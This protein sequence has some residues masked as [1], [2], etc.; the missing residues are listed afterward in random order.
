[1][2]ALTGQCAQVRFKPPKP[3]SAFTNQEGR[4]LLMASNH[5]RE[6]LGAFPKA[7]VNEAELL[8]QNVQALTGLR[9]VGDLLQHLGT[10]LALRCLRMEPRLQ[11]KEYAKRELI[12]PLLYVA[13]TLAG[14][15]FHIA[16]LPSATGRG[17]S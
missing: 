14:T 8:D 11:T 15:A 1:M 5:H 16:R 2:L 6:E 12:S 9:T 17:S 3:L 10:E 13:A 7:T 4:D